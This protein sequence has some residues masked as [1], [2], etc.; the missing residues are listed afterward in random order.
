MLRPAPRMTHKEIARRD[1]GFNERGSLSSE[2][3]LRLRR[4]FVY[5]CAVT[6]YTAAPG[7]ADCWFSGRYPGLADAQAQGIYSLLKLLLFRAVLRFL[8][9]LLQ[10]LQL[11]VDATGLLPL[12]IHEM[13]PIQ[14]PPIYSPLRR[15]S[16]TIAP[17]ARHS[18]GLARNRPPSPSFAGRRRRRHAAGSRGALPS[19]KRGMGSA[20][21]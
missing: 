2:G 3:R 10:P 18:L 21:W 19:Y 5:G 9:F 7:L 12:L 8:E 6:S 14:L 17:E 13:P 15:R 20:M 1:A 16:P 4:D 11:Q